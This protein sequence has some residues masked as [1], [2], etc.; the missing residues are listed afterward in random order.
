MP[1][2]LV[3]SGLKLLGRPPFMGKIITRLE[4]ATEALEYFSTRQWQWSTTAMQDLE[5]SMQPGDRAI[6][7]IDIKDLNWDSYMENY[8]YGTRHYVMKGDPSTVEASV[9]KGKLLFKAHQALVFSLTFGLLMLIGL[10]D[11]F[12]LPGKFFFACVLSWLFTTWIIDFRF[13]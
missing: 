4:K 2:L 3:D 10:L 7:G 1:A 9:R 11:P 8:A 5:K 6:F 13:E 12:D